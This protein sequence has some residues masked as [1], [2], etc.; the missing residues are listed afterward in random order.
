MR[1]FLGRVVCLMLFWALA[2]GM[3]KT[4]SGEVPLPE[5]DYKAAVRDDQDIPTKIHHATWEGVTFFIG[6]RGK[7]TVTVAFDK[8][9]KVVFVGAAGADNGD[10]QITLRS[11]DVV[12]VTFSNDAKLQGVTSYGSFRIQAKNIKE[13]AFE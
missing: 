6:T 11:G 8:V 12:T 13:I 9:K 10:F 7:G 3:S 2:V 4:P 1:R 5:V